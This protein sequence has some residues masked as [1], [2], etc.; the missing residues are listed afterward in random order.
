MFIENNE[1]KVTIVVPIYNKEKCLRKCLESIKKQTIE[2]YEV[3]MVDDGSIDSSA[4]IAKEYISDVRFRYVYQENSGVSVA[5][6][7]GIDLA[8]GD[9]ISFVDS[10]DS[11]EET[12]LEELLDSTSN[13]IDI[14]CCC[15]KYLENGSMR[16]NSFW[17]DGGVDCLFTDINT[18]S[19]INEYKLLPKK[20]LYFALLDTQYKSHSSR[21]TS[22]GVPWGKIYRSSFLKENVLYFD[23]VLIRYQDNIFNMFAFEAARYIYYIDIPL[24]IYDTRHVRNYKW[25]YN[26]K[27]GEFLDHL[28]RV[29]FDF[30]NS[31]KLLLDSDIEDLYYFEVMK[32]V[33]NMLRK[34]YL[35]PSN[36]LPKKKRYELIERK[37]SDEFYM[38]AINRGMQLN[39]YKS[40]RLRMYLLIKKR[41]R[42]IEIMNFFISKRD[43]RNEDSQEEL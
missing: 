16:K 15:C 32:H 36:P 33:D 23:P 4:K 38:N 41:Y 5:R 7:K 8:R 39:V 35:N 20:E 43:L 42:F 2:E 40:L 21:K 3:I 17:K 26:P 34:Y 6:N 22:I 25:R 24:Y 29:R 1:C 37:I 27:A 30:L 14:V 11:L 9:W 31:R 10:D 12:F 13:E 28:C 18:S 19:D